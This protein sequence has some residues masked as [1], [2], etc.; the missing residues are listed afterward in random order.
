V[1]FET[2]HGPYVISDD[3]ARLDL[4]VVHDWLANHSYWAEGRLLDTV[5]KSIANSV[6]LG[7][8]DEDGTTVGS[9]R[10]VTDFCTFAWLC[11]VFVL[12]EHRGHGL[13]KALV[14]TSVAHPQ[15]QDLKRYVLATADA[16]D[17]YRQYGFE[18]MSD[19]E[20]WMVRK[21]GIA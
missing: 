21:G 20:R 7:A 4:A 9:A 10:I 11:D 13:G 17:L 1:T 8:Y 18:V 14:E 3:P 15:L 16:H 6:V 2:H 19:P 12:D 5:R